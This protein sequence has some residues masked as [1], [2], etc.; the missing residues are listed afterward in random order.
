ME[1]AH[2]YT[3][4]IEQLP[5]YTFILN[6]SYFYGLFAVCTLVLIA[7]VLASF[8]SKTVA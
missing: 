4:T 8:S 5:L 6:R 1:I 7:I 2:H 3:A